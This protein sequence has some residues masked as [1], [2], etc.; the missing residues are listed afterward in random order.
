MW[1]LLMFVWKMSEIFFI[2]T[3]FVMNVFVYAKFTPRKPPAPPFFKFI[4]TRNQC[5]SQNYNYP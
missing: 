1:L 2:L 5:F 3:A 4:V